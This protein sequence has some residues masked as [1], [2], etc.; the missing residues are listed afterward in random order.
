[1]DRVEKG[2]G[3]GESEEE[4]VAR[5][6]L[7]DQLVRHSLR[8]GHMWTLSDAPPNRWFNYSRIGPS[9]EKRPEENEPTR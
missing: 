7:T 8:Q 5:F 1:M 2:D 6:R 3:K 9:D 4:L